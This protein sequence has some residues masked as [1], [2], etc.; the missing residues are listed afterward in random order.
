MSFHQRA[1]GAQ[2]QTH[3]LW[4]QQAID[5]LAPLRH[6]AHRLIETSL[7]LLLCLALG[8]LAAKAMRRRHLHWTWAVVALGCLLAL[9]HA[10]G[11]RELVVVGATAVAAITGRRWHRADLEAGADLAEIAAR[12]MTPLDVFARLARWATTSV[13]RHEPERFLAG[14]VLVLGDDD[15]GRPVSMPFAY[16]TQGAHTLVVGATGSGKT[17]TQTFMAAGAIERGAGAIVVDP[18]GDPALRAELLR[19]AQLAQRE[20]IEWTPDGQSVYNPYAR[21]SET[22]IADKV[23]ASERFTEPH[24]QR[25]AQRY[26]GHAVR[27]L[28]A[29]GLEVSLRQ[30][31]DCLDPQR[32]ESLARSQPDERALTTHAYLDS[33]TSRQRADLA[34]VRDRLAILAESDVGAWLDPASGETF[35]L[36]AAA[37]S[38]AVVYFD[39]EADSRPLL[40]QMLGGA[41]VQDLQTTV[42][43]LQACPTPTLVVI[44]EFSA[45]AV[46]Q[47]ARLFGRARSAGVSLL[48][49]TQELSDMRVPGRESVL[50]P[51]L[52]N[53]SLLVA[54]RQVVPD[55]AELIAAL[56]GT[57]GAWRTS[58]LGNGAVTRTRARERVLAPGDISALGAGWAA[59]IVLNDGSPARITRIRSLAAGR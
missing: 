26:L 14:E 12:R 5:P 8:L 36:L 52:G 37:R 17:V 35:D 56:G 25:Q 45:L 27:A 7:A 9:P 3:T 41:I 57:R 2:T 19:A 4:Q 51:V 40:A 50:E 54:H 13:S 6:A 47:V 39:L 46:D 59:V 48:L 34:G 16:T 11:G 33:L 49:G 23:L 1:R 53:L 22:E 18:K 42:A 44:D 15:R 43:A 24:Y 32:L 31:A 28:R 21:G 58:R 30:I 55:S 38:R 10:L 20:F 29:A